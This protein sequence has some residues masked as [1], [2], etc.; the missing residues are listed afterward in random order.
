MKRIIQRFV[1]KGLI[2]FPKGGAE[3]ETEVL[4]EG[5]PGD[6]WYSSR[7]ARARLQVGVGTLS[8]YGAAGKIE[9]LK[10]RHGRQERCYYLKADVENW[11]ENRIKNG[12]QNG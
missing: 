11:R 12:L 8:R 10:A 7:E 6:E 5:H 2:K 1:R 4:T 3:V 9:T